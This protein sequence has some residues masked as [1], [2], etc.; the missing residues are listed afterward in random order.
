MTT[1]FESIGVGIVEDD[2]HFRE[3]LEHL[4][5]TCEGM[6][7]VF[8]VGSCP[9]ALKAV[10]RGKTPSVVVMDL[11]LPGA[12]GMESIRRLRERCATTE[13]IVLTIHEDHERVFE[14]FCAGASGYL[15][16]SAS[17]DEIVDGIRTIAAGGSSLD[18][19]IA[20]RVLETFRSPARHR[21]SA[22]LTKREHEILQELARGHS[23]KNIAAT[24]GVSRHTID[25]HVRSIYAKLQARSR[26][27]AVAMALRSRII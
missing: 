3:T 18:A 15:L 5:K 16:K 9:A 10:T 6:H 13:F 11:E 27:A 7:C 23:L 22:V 14:S 1:T 24:L 26:A 12:S 19:F 4:V 2:R 21:S 25:T 20:R 8:A 17:A